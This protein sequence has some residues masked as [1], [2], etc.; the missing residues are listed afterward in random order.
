MTDR[1]GFP[2]GRVPKRR[3]DGQSNLPPS[4]VVSL[5][6]SSQLI[7]AGAVRAT[8][9]RQLPFWKEPKTR[10]RSRLVEWSE[11]FVCIC[12]VCRLCPV[13]PPLLFSTPMKR[14]NCSI[15]R[16]GSLSSHA[17]SMRLDTRI[18]YGGVWST[19]SVDVREWGSLVHGPWH[20]R[21]SNGHGPASA[22]VAL[23]FV[24][25]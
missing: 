13:F 6:V 1:L 5:L 4:C 11:I 9:L 22:C 15:R 21:K 14:T 17:Q 18:I 23:H 3:Q 16:I 12:F 19:K 25:S 7:G 8:P 20:S 2:A 10:V 24:L